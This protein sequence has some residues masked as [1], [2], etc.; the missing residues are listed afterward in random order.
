L[1]DGTGGEYD[2]SKGLKVVYQQFDAGGGLVITL[3]YVENVKTLFTIAYL[4]ISVSLMFFSA[5]SQ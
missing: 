2:S 3:F 1:H 5:R 4:S